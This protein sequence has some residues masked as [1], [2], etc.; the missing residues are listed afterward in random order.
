MAKGD[1]TPK[2]WLQKAL[3][4]TATDST[5][6]GAANVRRYITAISLVNTGTTARTVSV[7]GWG[8]AASNQIIRVPVA[9]NGGSEV[10]TDLPWFVENGE[11]FYFKQDTGTD[12]NVTIMGKEEALA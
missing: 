3:T 5:V 6:V 8:T 1:F 7:Y 4:A 10:L 12:V 2:K 11:S 9:A